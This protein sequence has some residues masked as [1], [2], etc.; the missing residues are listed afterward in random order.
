MGCFGPLA[1]GDGG[2][3]GR[4]WIRQPGNEGSTL[5]FLLIMANSFNIMT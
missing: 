4:N 5:A 1:R 2:F 3:S